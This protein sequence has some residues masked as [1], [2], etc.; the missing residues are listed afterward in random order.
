VMW[1]GLVFLL[2]VVLVLGY[3]IVVWSGFDLC[4]SVIDGFVTFK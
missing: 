3:C 2:G 4:L 1:V